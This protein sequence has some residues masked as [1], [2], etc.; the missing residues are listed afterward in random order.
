MKELDKCILCPRECKVNRNNQEVGLC[1][2]TNKIKVARIAM[3]YY[4][5][6]PISGEKG[7]GA[8]FFSGCNMKCIFCQNYKISINNFGKEITISNLANKMLELQ[9]EGANNINLVTP[10]IYIPQIK[11]TLNLAKKR[12]LKIPIVY[13]TSSYEKKE[14]LKLLENLVDIYLP[15]L[16]YYDDFLA[17]RYSKAPNYFQ[18]AIDAIDEMY[19]QV[20]PP[21]FNKKNI[22]TKGIIVRVLLLPGKLEDA[23]NIIKYLHT[24]YND[25]IF[26]S[27]MNQ[28]TPTSQ[29]KNIEELN[30]TVSEK[31]Y[32]E[33]INFACDLNI[34]NAF[35]QGKE[36]AKDSFIPEFDLTGIN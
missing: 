7:S 13:N 35:I 6:P 36:T 2:A 11:K 4:E 3:H 29:V 18:I 14:S 32:N 5:E 28:Y 34:K 24:T 20:G 10:T 15:D 8:I 26:I 27:I 16:K 1:G 9:K 23:K 21:K 22:M 12:G 17:M 19:K 30:H 31:E 25:K 33:L